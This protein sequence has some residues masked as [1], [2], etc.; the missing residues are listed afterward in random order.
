MCI[1]NIGDN[2]YI[3]TD[4]EVIS[5]STCGKLNVKGNGYFFTFKRR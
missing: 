1:I 2:Q 3:K 5:Y 4:T